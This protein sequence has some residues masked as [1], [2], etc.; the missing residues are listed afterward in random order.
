MEDL[1]DL[2]FQPWGVVAWP[3]KSQEVTRYRLA[4]TFSPGQG[5]QL[6]SLLP[7]EDETLSMT[8]PQ[9]LSQPPT[10]GVSYRVSQ[11]LPE[12]APVKMQITGLHLKPILDLIL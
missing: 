2:P 9:N 12:S 7:W 4:F 3:L 11:V 10:T 6:V 5:Q 1:M 8:L